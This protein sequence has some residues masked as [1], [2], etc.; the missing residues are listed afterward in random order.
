MSL[1][2]EASFSSSK[3]QLLLIAWFEG[4][5]AARLVVTGPQGEREEI[6]INSITAS[7]DDEVKELLTESSPPAPKKTAK[8]TARLNVSTDRTRVGRAVKLGNRHSKADH[9]CEKLVA[10]AVLLAKDESIQRSLGVVKQHFG[11]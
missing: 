8:L 11:R 1:E 9:L 5:S 7:L 4:N 10:M 3:G 6:Q 2:I